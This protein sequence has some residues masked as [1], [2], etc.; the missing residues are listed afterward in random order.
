MIIK[1]LGSAA[2]GGFPQWNCNCDNCVAVRAQTPGFKPRTQSSLAVSRDGE[3]WA[4]LNASPDLREQLLSALVNL[5]Y[6]RSRAE[7]VVETAVAEA[8]EEAGIE[9]LIRIALR[10]LAR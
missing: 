10:S 5:G 4:L 9:S 2:G 3:N 6:P 8:G 1:V 7:R